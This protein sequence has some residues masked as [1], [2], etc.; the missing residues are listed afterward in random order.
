[1]RVVLIGPQLAALPGRRL[2][3]PCKRHRPPRLSCR[4]RR[5]RHHISRLQLE[6]RLILHAASHSLTVLPA[7]ILK[8]WKG[9]IRRVGFEWKEEG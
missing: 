3:W 8:I 9:Y 5:G 1:M 7:Y 2:E 4:L 6:N